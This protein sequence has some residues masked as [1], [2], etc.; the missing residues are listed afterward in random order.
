MVVLVCYLNDLEDRVLVVGKAGKG[1]LAE[2]LAEGSKP[3]KS[4]RG[5]LQRLRDSCEMLMRSNTKVGVGVSY[6]REHPISE[7]LHPPH[8]RRQ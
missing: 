8:S 7:P 4:L 3:Q 5:K 1:V 6:L 2:I